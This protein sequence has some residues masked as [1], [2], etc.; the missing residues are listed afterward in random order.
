[1]VDQRI[2]EE[3]EVEGLIPPPYSY[4][5]SFKFLIFFMIDDVV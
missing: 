2:E 1:V 4:S 3:K 5:S